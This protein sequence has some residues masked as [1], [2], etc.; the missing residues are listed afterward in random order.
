M[1]V[2]NIKLPFVRNSESASRRHHCWTWR[3]IP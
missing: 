2:V 1:C 3:H